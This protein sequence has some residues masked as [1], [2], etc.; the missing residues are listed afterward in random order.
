MFVS[1]GV[2]R[3]VWVVADGNRATSTNKPYHIPST[4]CRSLKL[5]SRGWPYGS[6]P[7]LV[8]ILLQFYYPRENGSW[9]MNCAPISHRTTTVAESCQARSL[10]GGASFCVEKMIARNQIQLNSGVVQVRNKL[11]FRILQERPSNYGR[12]HSPYVERSVIRE[13]MLPAT[14]LVQL[15]VCPCSVDCLRDWNT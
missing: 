14:P 8:A 4:R 1:A 3:A 5:K 11:A 12:G 13:L 9:L 2:A 7:R 15:E 10:S 6:C